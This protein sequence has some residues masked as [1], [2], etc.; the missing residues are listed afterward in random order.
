METKAVMEIQ[1]G[2]S[3]KLGSILQIEKEVEF[4]SNSS[5]KMSFKKNT[6]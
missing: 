4:N 2:H 1:D 5:F 6:G 3:E